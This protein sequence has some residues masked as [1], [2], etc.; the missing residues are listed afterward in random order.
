MFEN[1]RL[2]RSLEMDRKTK[3]DVRTFVQTN[4]RMYVQSCHKHVNLKPIHDI[5]HIAT[6]TLIHTKPLLVQFLFILTTHCIKVVNKMVGT[7]IDTSI[8]TDQSN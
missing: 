8:N 5:L 7:S 1:P 6:S 4:R 2:N 3:C